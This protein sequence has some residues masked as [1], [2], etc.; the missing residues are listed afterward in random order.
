MTGYYIYIDISHLPRLIDLYPEKTKALINELDKVFSAADAT[1]VSAERSDEINLFYQFPSTTE[2]TVKIIL[3]TVSQTQKVLKGNDEIF[4]FNTLI[5][6]S[7]GEAEDILATL[8]SIHYK[9]PL[10]GEV[11][12]LNNSDH[13]EQLL[14]CERHLNFLRITDFSLDKEHSLNVLQKKYL[15]RK[16]EAQRLKKLWKTLDGGK[17]IAVVGSPGGGK[18]FTL[19]YLFSKWGFH[20]NKIYMDALSPYQDPTEP[21]LDMLNS[22]EMITFR[23]TLAE[24]GEL[25][26]FFTHIKDGRRPNLRELHYDIGMLLRSFFSFSP[27]AILILDHLELWPATSLAILREIIDSIPEKPII[28]TASS[29]DV[30][31]LQADELLRFSGKE[32]EEESNNSQRELYHKALLKEKGQF[33]IKSSLQELFLTGLSEE[34]RRILAVI[35]VAPGYF[36]RNSIVRFFNNPKVAEDFDFLKEHLFMKGKEYCYPIY[37]RSMLTIDRDILKALEERCV[38]FCKENPSPNESEY[39][40][41]LLSFGEENDEHLTNVIHSLLQ[42]QFL[43]DALLISKRIPGN[44]D[45]RSASDSWIALYTH[46]RKELDRCVSQPQPSP[47]GILSHAFIFYE[48]GEIE[49]S[50]EEARKALYNIQNKPKKNSKEKD[51]CLY[52]HGLVNMALGKQVEALNYLA[53][54]NDDIDP[55]I[56]IKKHLHE[57]ISHFLNGTYF[58]ALSLCNVVE[59]SRTFYG[60]YDQ[61]ALFFFV[62][63]RILFEIGD[64]EQAEESFLRGSDTAQKYDY[65]E[66]SQIATLWAGRACFYAGSFHRGMGHIENNPANEEKFYY[67]AEAFCINNEIQRATSI[68][69]KALPLARRKAEGRHFMPHKWINGYQKVEGMVKSNNGKEDVFLKMM[70]AFYAYLKLMDNELKEASLLLEEISVRPTLGSPPPYSHLFHF[71]NYLHSQKLNDEDRNEKLYLSYGISTLQNWAAK[72]DDSTMRNSFINRNYWNRMIFLEGQ[73]KNLV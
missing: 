68:M 51:L 27:P 15:F 2:E 41:L 21:F 58:A 66:I 37:K 63:G 7:Y 8:K 28:T 25:H 5:Y 31:F 55:D 12:F 17:V 50:Y 30:F 3:E 14:N 57:T 11:W 19:R 33:L 59:K 62:K 60:N 13:F 24:N 10:D 36:R 40:H 73:K 48:L 9:L 22:P 52:L 46:N 65:G 53:L 39:A 20:H 38:T 16:D 42:R 61:E 26:N 47:E 43:T 1:A 23:E 56:R 29:G 32:R 72:I 6:S 67:I 35:D 64:Y 69:E 49:N 45:V 44:D 4:E 70:I 34:R 18:T 71:F 54:V